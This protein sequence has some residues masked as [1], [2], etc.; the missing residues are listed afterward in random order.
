MPSPLRK[1]VP[2]QRNGMARSS[3][4]PMSSTR[5]SDSCR[6]RLTFESSSRASA[7]PIPPS[8]KSIEKFGSPML[9]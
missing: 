2:T 8:V 5:E 1:S 7:L 4:E 9:S 6:M 3:N